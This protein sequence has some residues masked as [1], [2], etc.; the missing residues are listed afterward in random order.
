MTSD[1]LQKQM[2]AEM[3]DKEIFNQAK[4]HAFDYAGK[5]L[6]RNVYPTNEAIEQ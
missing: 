2:Q 3:V 4:E 5:A 6:E 1:T